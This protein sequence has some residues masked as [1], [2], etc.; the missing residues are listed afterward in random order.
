MSAKECQ[1]YRKKMDGEAGALYA[2]T[3]GK[4]GSEGASCPA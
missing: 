4:V 3:E 2:G 1:R